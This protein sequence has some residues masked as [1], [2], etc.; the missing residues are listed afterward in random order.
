MHKMHLTDY[1]VA[2]LCDGGFIFNEKLLKEVAHEFGR[3]VC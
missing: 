2:E 3:I 1:Y